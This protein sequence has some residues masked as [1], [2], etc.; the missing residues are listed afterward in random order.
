MIRNV[1]QA[2]RSIANMNQLNEG[3]AC[4]KTDL[5]GANLFMANDPTAGTHPAGLTYSFVIS[6][7]TVPTVGVLY[8]ITTGAAD[9]DYFMPAVYGDW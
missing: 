7:E 4:P 6:S 3:D 8:M 9:A 2:V 5:F 1:Q